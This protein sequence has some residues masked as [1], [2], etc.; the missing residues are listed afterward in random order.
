MKRWLLQ[1][2]AVL[3]LG[4][5]CIAQTAAPHAQRAAA[6][7]P[8]ER[9]YLIA[10]TLLDSA[11]GAPIP[12]ATVSLVNDQ[13]FT[14]FRSVQTGDDGKFQFD[15]M[16]AGR[17]G[18]RAARRGYM[19]AFLDEHE[20][21]SS[22]VV[23]GD[24]LDTGSIVFRLNPDAV[25]RGTVTD[26]AGEPVPQAQVLLARK[27]HNSGRGERLEETVSGATDDQGVFEYWNLRPGTY[28]LAVKAMPWFALRPSLQDENRNPQT[29]ALDV[30]YPVTYYDGTTDAAAAAPIT[31]AAGDQQELNVSLH[32]VP[33]LRLMVRTGAPDSSG[34]SV[35][36]FPILS[37]TILG[38]QMPSFAA[39]TQPT[40]PGLVELTGIAPGHYSLTAGTP[41]RI[42]DVDAGGSGSVE[43]DA[44]TGVPAA[45]VTVIPRMADGSS[46]P[47]SLQLML[48]SDG[49]EQRTITGPLLPTGEIRFDAVPP[50]SWTLV[51]Q[52]MAGNQV[53][54]VEALQTAAGLRAG[55]RIDVGSHPVRL[56]AVLARG[57]TRVQGIA[58]KDSKGLPGVMIV[59][60]PDHPEVNWPLFRRDQT[61]SD[62][63]FN[64]HDAAPG[65]YTVVAIEN[66]WGMDWARPEVIGRYLPRGQ[67]VTLNSQSGKAVQLPA[68]VA[69]QPRE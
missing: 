26:D 29:A 63:S 61:D 19:T 66:G 15:P 31:L 48:V 10:G 43:V 32:A 39:P 46:P 55:S 1:I 38:S 47:S 49:P 64:L 24:G 57:I 21:F 3:L 40:T 45:R 16:P 5:A 58:Q 59:L 68:P 36:N 27:T 28:L 2:A 7:V 44:A 22:A 41:P 9:L 34:R 67:A 54:D 4:Q 62:G 65:R 51:A 53:L 13:D 52:P 50:G 20:E 25:V 18:L 33:A 17:Y 69:V 6:P 30:A 14:L 37:Q 42:S 60:V 12:R 35:P 56:A 23:T 8:P 11:T